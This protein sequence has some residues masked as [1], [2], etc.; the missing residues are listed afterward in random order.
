MV[1]FCSTPEASSHLQ[2]LVVR[3]EGRWKNLETWFNAMET[4]PAYLGTRSDHYTHVHDLPPQL[5]GKP[6][7]TRQVE[8]DDGCKGADLRNGLSS[9]GDE[10]IEMTIKDI[11]TVSALSS[12]TFM[13]VI[14]FIQAHSSPLDKLS[15]DRSSHKQIS[16]LKKESA[17]I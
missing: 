10:Q 15:S 7:Y 11:D 1:S 16:L 17:E 13:L 14:P 12:Q 8:C 2:G 5:G 9:L 6:H 3:G 4:R